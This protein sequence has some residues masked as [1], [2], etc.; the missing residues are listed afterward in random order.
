MLGTFTVMYL[1][2]GCGGIEGSTKESV[3]VIKVKMGG[4]VL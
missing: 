3:K 4:V 2:I 1:V